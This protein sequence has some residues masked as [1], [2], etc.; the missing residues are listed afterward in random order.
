MKSRSGFTLLEV[1][2]VVLI[3]TILATIV[4]INV[5]PHL[6]KANEAKAIA[7]IQAFRTGLKLF[8]MDHGRYPTQEQ[9]LRALCEPPTQPPLVT[10]FPPEGYLESRKVPLDPWGREYVY[11]APGPGGSPFEI[12][13]YGADGEPGG[14]GTNADISSLNL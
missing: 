3:V 6:G 2:V 11:L 9:G 5:L 7:Q 12:V 4:G 8:H 13:T 10:K 14:D 1:L